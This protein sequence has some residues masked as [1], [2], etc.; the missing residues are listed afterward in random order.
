MHMIEQ[1]EQLS[2]FSFKQKGLSWGRNDK[3]LTVRNYNKDKRQ[4]MQQYLE[5]L[6]KPELN[7]CAYHKENKVFMLVLEMN[8]PDSACRWL[9]LLLEDVNFKQRFSI[10]GA[11]NGSKAK[12][13]VRL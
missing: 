11:K 8:K 9:D 12:I 4:E 5:K 3:I 7:S 1:Q 10:P 2:Q 13:K 6:M